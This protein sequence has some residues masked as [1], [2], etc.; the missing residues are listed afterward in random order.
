MSI[1]HIVFYTKVADLSIDFIILGYSLF[2]FGISH[3]TRPPF[4]AH[5]RTRDLFTATSIRQDG[6]GGTLGPINSFRGEALYNK[7]P[8]S[9]FTFPSFSPSA[10]AFSRIAPLSQRTFRDTFCLFLP[11][12]IA[13]IYPRHYAVFSYPKNIGS[14]AEAFD[15]I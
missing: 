3:K 6:D 1:I 2:I 7:Y 9:R 14:N 12:G 13:Y 8:S 10:I 11:I 4:C 5:R 15:P